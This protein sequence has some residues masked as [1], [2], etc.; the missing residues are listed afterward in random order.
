MFNE[1]PSYLGGMTT[2]MQDSMN[3][4]QYGRENVN[5]GRYVPNQGAQ[6]TVY[7]E[8]PKMQQTNQTVS[9]ILPLVEKYTKGFE[10][11]EFHKLKV[12]SSLVQWKPTPKEWLIVLE[13][14]ES[15]LQGGVDP[16]YLLQGEASFG[17]IVLEIIQPGTWGLDAPTQITRVQKLKQHFM[18]QLDIPQ[19]VNHENATR[20]EEEL[21]RNS[22]P[23]PN[24]AQNNLNQVHNQQVPNAQ[25][26]VNLNQFYQNQQNQEVLY[27]NLPHNQVANHN[28]V[29]NTNETPWYMTGKGMV[30]I[31]IFGVIGWSWYRNRDV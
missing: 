10:P 11:V 21:N 29:V 16:K 4:V 19:F 31:A 8:Q 22:A 1:Q 3:G 23:M 28:Q 12:P 6:G 24:A 7:R 9:P 25:D 18:E 13:K 30:G 20:R 14:Y 5:D 26:L 27:A 15:G 2:V 17:P